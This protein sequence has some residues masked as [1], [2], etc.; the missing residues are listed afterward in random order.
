MAP[1]ARRDQAAQAAIEEAPEEGAVPHCQLV[2][3]AL[4]G[5]Y[6]GLD[7]DAVERIIELP[8]ITAVPHT[9]P[10]IAGLTNLRG[11]VLPVLDL[12]A[13]F[14]LPPGE[15]TPAARVV[16]VRAHDV[17]VGVLVDAVR[18]VVRVAEQDVEP[19][20]P[21]VAPIDAAYIA[22]VVKAQGP[23]VALLDLAQVVPR[24]TSR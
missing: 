24:P 18:E 11:A 9:P 14:E 4:A 12:R 6:Y 22:G 2:V 10:Y 23:L 13:R 21:L 5:E 7:I 16:V 3:V 1:E 20:S 8:H 15:P 19:P 17:A